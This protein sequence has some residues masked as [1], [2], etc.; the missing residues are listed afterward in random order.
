MPDA[1]VDE[2]AAIGTPDQVAAALRR[3]VD[4]GATMP[5]AILMAADQESRLRMLATLGE[6]IAA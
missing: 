4:A 1:L 5:V 6:M 2:T 3:F